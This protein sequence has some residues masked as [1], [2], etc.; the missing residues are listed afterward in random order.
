MYS[1]VQYTSTP[2]LAVTWPLYPCLATHLTT[3]SLV[4][5]NNHSTLRTAIQLST[6]AS[7]LSTSPSSQSNR[8]LHK[9]C[10]QPFQSSNSALRLCYQSLSS[11]SSLN[12]AIPFSTQPPITQHSHPSHYLAIHI[13]TWLPSLNIEIHLIPYTVKNVYTKLW[14]IPVPCR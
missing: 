1:I 11:D 2:T 13:T 8:Y 12:L 5:H 7:H 4:Y 6:W 14:K 3:W 9:L 10:H